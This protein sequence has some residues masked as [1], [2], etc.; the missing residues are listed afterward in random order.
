VG[1]FCAFVFPGLGHL[2]SGKPV[3][4]LVWFVL[5][6]AG[7]AAFI[8]PGIL[9][10]LVSIVDAVRADRRNTIRAISEGV[11]RGKMR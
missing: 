9:L 3:Q 7:Y 1:G 8:V 4:A 6:V 10:H 5:I 11:R 2:V